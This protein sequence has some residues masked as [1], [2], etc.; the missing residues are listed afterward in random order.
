MVD[1]E[2]LN[3]KQRRAYVVLHLELCSYDEQNYFCESRINSAKLVLEGNKPY[4]MYDLGST[5]GHFLKA[6]QMILHLTTLSPSEMVTVLE[7]LKR[8]WADTGQETE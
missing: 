4:H 2:K 7:H 6:V 8:L 1:M 3:A 5:A